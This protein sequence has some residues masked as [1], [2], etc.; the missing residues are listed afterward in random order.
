[1]S[2]RDA[3]ILEFGSLCIGDS[4]QAGFLKL[5]VTCCI[6]GGGVLEGFGHDVFICGATYRTAHGKLTHPSNTRAELSMSGLVPLSFSQ[7][8][9]F[10]K[11]RVVG[12]G[13]FQSYFSFIKHNQ[14]I[15]ILSFGE[16]TNPR[17][18]TLL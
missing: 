4:N 18:P 9:F 16:K 14:F 12:I 13:T 10:R 7:N 2:P 5:N 15:T 6:F 11:F 3:G 17:K 1:M 8:C